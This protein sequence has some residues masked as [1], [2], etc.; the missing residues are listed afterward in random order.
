MISTLIFVYLG[1]LGITMG[2]RAVNRFLL[3]TD[4][5]SQSFKVDWYIL[6]N[7]AFN[8]ENFNIR[9]MDYQS[10]IPFYNVFQALTS[11]IKY[12]LNCS[13]DFGNLDNLEIIRPMANF[14]KVKYLRNPTIMNLFKV[15][16]EGRQRLLCANYFS[17]FSDD[18]RVSGEVLYEE[19]NGD[20]TVLEAFGSFAS[21]LTSE[22]IEILQND[23]KKRSFKSFIQDDGE[24]VAL[25]INEKFTGENCEQKNLALGELQSDIEKLNDVKVKKKI[26]GRRN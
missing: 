13:N 21:I 23:D 18:G 16:R 14:E 17:T 22:I 20:I 3:V 11:F 2:M 25:S 24:K 7:Q 4:L 26:F 5:A 10:F 6:K 19:E 15:L 1:S 9:K 8:V 12:M